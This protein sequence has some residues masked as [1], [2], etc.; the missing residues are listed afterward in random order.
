MSKYIL[1]RI[2]SSIITLWVVITATFILAHIIPG[3][4]FDRDKILPPE[5][6]KNIQQRYNLD[7]PLTWQYQ[8]YISHLVKLDLGPSFQQRGTSVNDII[9]R[10]FP[11]SARLGVVAVSISLVFGIIL[12]IIS[13]YKQGKW[14]DNLAMF[15]STLGVTI[16]SFVVATLLI[17]VF[18]ETLRWLPVFGL[19]SPKHYI[20]PAIALSGFS[21]AFVSR[22]IR[23]SLLEVIRQDYIRAARARGLSEMSIVFVHS[24]RNAVLPVITYIGPLV[25]S[26][27]TGSFVVERIFTIPGLGRSFVDSIANR[28]YTLVLGVTVFYSILLIVCNLL[29]DIIYALVDP[30]INIEG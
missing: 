4:P 8:D 11:V 15:I 25:A 30:R 17:Y 19:S 18:G 24:L 10:G 3:G 26:I 7:K 1:K 27:L 29:V 13:A 2:F 20:L 6:M 28:D 14:E 9:N 21:M 16:P 22:L 23:S 5:V 12:G